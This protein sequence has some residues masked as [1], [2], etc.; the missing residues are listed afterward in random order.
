MIHRRDVRLPGKDPIA[1]IVIG[2]NKL[3]KLGADCGTDVSNKY[4][5]LWEASKSKVGD[6][7]LSDYSLRPH[8]KREAFGTSS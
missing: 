1:D 2:Y 4:F 8:N 7:G 5:I 3:D 6:S